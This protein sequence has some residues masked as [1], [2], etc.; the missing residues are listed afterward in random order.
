M[1]YL[2]VDTEDA[3]NFFFLK[4]ASMQARCDTIVENMNDVESESL[5]RCS[6][7]CG[8]VSVGGNRDVEISEM[9]CETL[10]IMNK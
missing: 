4:Y 9:P 6:K 2:L 1:E 5:E 7:S 10:K 3:N 8:Q